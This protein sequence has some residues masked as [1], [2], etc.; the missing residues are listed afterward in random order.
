MNLIVS[1]ITSSIIIKRA[2]TLNK[3]WRTIELKRGKK[4]RKRSCWLLKRHRNETQK[5]KANGEMERKRI[6]SDNTK[7]LS[8]KRIN[9]SL[10]LSTK[11][12]L[13]KS[14]FKTFKN[15][16]L[17]SFGSK[18]KTNSKICSLQRGNKE[19]YSS[20]NPR[21]RPTTSISS[22]TA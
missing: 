2:R 12:G 13:P 16:K 8:T 18:T 1:S 6:K 22:S 20:T 15:S 17:N 10:K 3:T 19:T 5:S 21:S 7:P 11:K 4:R 14:T 9:R